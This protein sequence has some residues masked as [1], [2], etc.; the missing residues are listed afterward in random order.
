MR[1]AAVLRRFIIGSLILGLTVPMIYHIAL[2]LIRRDHFSGLA[3]QVC[4]AVEPRVQIGAYREALEAAQ[5]VVYSQGLEVTPNVVFVDRGKVMTPEGADPRN[6]LQEACEFT[7]ISGVSLSIHY[8]PPPLANPK[9]LYLY[10]FSVPV[11]LILFLLARWGIIRIQKKVADRIE[12]QMKV[13]LGMQPE[14]P[15]ATSLIDRAFDLELPLVRYL[16][17]HIEALSRGLDSYSKKIAEQQKREVLTDV[18]AQVA[19]DIVA[20]IATLQKILGEES[21]A[22]NDELI[23]AELARIKGLSEKL[24]NQYRGNAP[25]AV[26]RFDLH[27][28]IGLVVHEVSAIS[29]AARI[30]GDLEAALGLEVNGDFDEFVSALSNI[31]RNSLEALDKAEKWVRV[32]VIQRG[33]LAEIEVQDNGCGIGAEN[34][35]RIFDKGMTIGKKKGTGLGLFQARNAL[36][37]MG[38]QIDLES[39]PGVG[40]K[41]R[42]VVPV[43]RIEEPKYEIE[44]TKDTQLVF[45]DDDFLVHK[46]WKIAL[47]DL[48]LPAGMPKPLHFMS[49]LEFRE[50]IAGGPSEKAI[51]FIDF[52]LD[53]SDVSGFDLIL[54]LGIQAQS[55][56]VSG[57]CFSQEFKE[58][59]KRCGVMLI[60]KRSNDQLIFRVASERVESPD[61]VFIDD[62]KANQI[63]WRLAA[64]R[65]GRRIA[66][67]DSPAA[68]L[69]NCSMVDKTVP[70][71]VDFHFDGATE[72]GCA[73]A[74]K[75]LSMGF[76]KVFIATGYPSSKIKAPA[77]LAGIIGKEFPTSMFS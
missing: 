26:E 4:K 17:N 72:T 68:F 10:F 53:K 64:E 47:A 56:L 23:K 2:N 38:G 76:E 24:L 48:K 12:G 44:L 37:N 27:K 45:V 13:L 46:T 66:L 3:A 20:P 55:Y 63:T 75:L 1:N 22:R 35:S 74:E 57:E 70:I 42:L 32:S 34:L 29:G 61:L 59:A 15:K 62:S 7:G 5:A 58:V 65:L 11:L 28:A 25:A 19:H 60:G 30:D 36:Q 51:F 41:V 52:N 9:Y 16:K 18:A 50:W 40:T 54:E 69:E 43:L 14:A 49:A 73:G 8:A 33:P 67:F 39:T 21:E 77:G 71:F 6:T 31:L